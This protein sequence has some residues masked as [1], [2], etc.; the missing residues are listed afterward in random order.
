MI[1]QIIQRAVA[2]SG[3]SPD[4]AKQLIELPEKELF[5]GATQ[6]REAHFGNR[7]QL[8]SIINAKS[9]KC[10][11]DCSFCSQSGHHSTQ[12]ESYPFL[13]NPELKSRIQ[14]TIADSKRKCG[15]V[16]SGGKLSEQELTRLE[17]VV[18]DIGNGEDPAVCASL[19]RLTAEE[20]SRLK[21]SGI[22]RFHHNLEA[23]ANYYPTVCSTQK[24]EQRL[25][26]VKAALAAGMQVCSGGLFGL[27]ESWQDR[28]DLAI[29]LRELGIDSVPVNFLYS[30]EGTPLEAVPPMQASEALRIIAVY[31]YLL[32]KK[33][34]RICGGRSH[35]LGDR[36]KELFAAGANGLMT[37][38]YLT[39]AGS[40]YENDLNMIREL[41]LVIESA[42]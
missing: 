9:G 36:Q 22:G 14:E 11:M 2:G 5:S 19:G 23:S 21:A 24:W 8:C 28:I 13:E 26:T 18:R 7:I 12:I 25:D 38:N 42:N 34:L 29:T 31:R 15:V 30:H 32:P 4:E 20:L 3:C 35:V 16:T 1:K 39:V 33:T 6:I 27:G 41:R 17:D 37:G 10:D 40:Q